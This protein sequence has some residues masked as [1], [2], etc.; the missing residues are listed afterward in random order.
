[1]LPDTTL[2]SNLQNR[3]YLD[4]LLDGQPNLEALFAQIAPATVREELQKAQ[5][6]PERVPRALKKFIDTLTS[7]D[8]V[9]HLLKNQKSN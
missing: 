1:M 8:S 3:Q 6:N 9:K 7:P 2:V 4:I 5:Q